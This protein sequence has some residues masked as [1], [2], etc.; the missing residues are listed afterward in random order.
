MGHVSAGDF[1]LGAWERLIMESAM[2]ADEL[3]PPFR[4]SVDWIWIVARF[5]T[6]SSKEASILDTLKKRDGQGLG[7]WWLDPN[8]L[9]LYRKD[10]FFQSYQF[11]RYIH[12]CGLESWNCFP[13]FIC[14]RIFFLLWSCVLK[15]NTLPQFL[16]QGHEDRP[17]ADRLVDGTS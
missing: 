6:M 17:K 16:H 4:A 9:I 13:Q 1:L 15:K 7:C 3:C 14:I 10:M 12:L 2:G 5:D 8:C 11:C